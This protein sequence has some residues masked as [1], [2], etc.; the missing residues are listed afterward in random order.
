MRSESTSGRQHHDRRWLH[1]IL[2]RKVELAQV[3]AASV[4]LILKAKDHEVPDEDVLW[5]GSCD[6][7]IT[8]DAP[9]G[10]VFYKLLIL[11]RKC[12]KLFLEAQNPDILHPL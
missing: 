1:G 11:L 6:E 4:W 2:S 8:G 9:I 5:I 3:V 7:I 10:T 12:P